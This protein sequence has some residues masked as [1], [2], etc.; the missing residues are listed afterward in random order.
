MKSTIKF[1]VLTMLLVIAIAAFAGC[2]KPVEHNWTEATCT[3]PKTCTDC[4][5]VEGEALGHTEQIIAG[6][7]ATCTETG[8]TEGKSCSVCNATI[9]AQEEIPALGH[10]YMFP[11]DAHCQVCGELGNENAAHTIV[12]VEAKAATCTA[13]G[14]VAY[15]YCSDCGAAWADEAL[16]Q[17]TNQKNVIV[18][19]IGHAYMFPCDAHCMACGELT[20][21]NAAHTIVAVAAKAAT[22]TAN[23]NVAYWYCSDCGAAWADEAL[24]QVTNRMNVIIPAPGHSYMFPCDAHCMV[25]GELTNP[26]AA[27]TIV[28]V[29]AKA[30]T[31]TANGNVAYWTCSDCGAAW[32][33]E[34]LTLV[35]NRMS[36]IVPATGHA[37]FYA[38]DAHCM[39]CYELTNENAAHTIVAVEAKAA[40]CTANGNVA[41]WTCSDCGGAWLDEALTFVANR[42][43]VIVPA[44]GHAYM[45]ACDAHCMNCGELTNENA[46]HTIVA[47][48]AKAATCTEN[49]NVAYWTC[50]DCGGAW[51]DEALTLVANRMSVTLPATGHTYVGFSCETDGVCSCGAIKP[52]AHTLNYVA[53]AVATTCLETGHDE[54]W[55]CTACGACFGDA[56]G[57][58][59]VNPAWLFYTGECQRPEGAADCA[60]VPCLVC[61]EDTYGYGDH[62]VVVCKGGLCTKCNT[63][64]DGYGCANYDTPACEDGFCSYC[65]DP[66]EG[67]GHENGAWAPCQDGECSYGCGLFY[68]ATE[69]HIDEDG[70][71]FCDTCYDHLK[72]DV[73]PCL[74]GECSI[75]WTYVEGAH[76]Y[77]YPCDQICSVCYELT[78]PDATHTIVAVEAKAATCT[79]N[80]NVAYWYCSDCGAAWANE[81]LT[82]VTNQRNVIIPALGHAD[83]NGDYKC[84]KCSTKMLPEAGT[85]LTIPQAIAIGKLFTKDTYTTQKYYIT[86]IVTNV[87]NTTYGNLYLKDAD[88]NQI[89]I[90]GLYTYD[91]STRYDK[92]SYKPVEGDELTVYTVLGF[93][94]EAQGKNAWMDEVVAHEHNYTSVVKEATC[95]NDG[96]TTHTCTICNDSYTDTEVAA[97]GHTTENGT[98]ERCGNEIGGDAPAVKD[99]VTFELGANGSASHND[100]TDLT[101][102]KTYTEGSATLKITSVTK[103]YSGARDAKG[104]SCLKFGTSKLTGSLTF[105]VDDDV[106]SVVIYVA[107]YKAATSTNIKINGT[108]YTVKTA[109]NN[110]EYT[111]IEIDTTTTKT[112]TF[113]T[114]TYRCMVNSI[115]YNYD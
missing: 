2:A 113:T 92:M 15:W 81:E 40:T 60:T 64:I 29:E 43:S 66:V 1:L 72:H 7:A 101:A 71:D 54:Y 11:C 74:G 107:G 73:D 34:A 20:N 80:G 25:C 89:C 96:Y 75:C 112:I 108:Q 48:E 109:S 17:L 31:C 94:T 18:P 8:L 32:L 61:G 78:N 46:A 21:P 105:T 53:A 103:V 90:Y 14:N 93:Y 35:A 82:Q 39:N 49:G 5:A 97:L 100:G 51:L 41:Y 4:G 104:N 27:H 50:S 98:C 102:P 62:D 77:T 68:P 58:W 91:G 13:T 106:T 95:T 114:V 65:G 111:A 12:A 28:A 70:D 57:S 6:K 83:E 16:T 42:M 44:T 110:G 84:D 79:A 33:D 56:D 63:E 23:G 38:C 36:V 37:Y 9:V 99:P 76:T 45:F 88:G 24:T 59:Q 10:S 26:N 86:G 47:V 22:C 55:E 85:T 52:A 69:D 30:A 115:T 67:F 87:Y 19:E 3:A